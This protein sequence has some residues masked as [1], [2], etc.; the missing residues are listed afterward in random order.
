M[1][2]VKSHMCNPEL[3]SHHRR[4]IIL[5]YTV[6]LLLLQLLQ[7]THTKQ[8]YMYLSLLH[9][10]VMPSQLKHPRPHYPYNTMFNHQKFVWISPP[11]SCITDPLQLL[12]LTVHTFCSTNIGNLY[13]TC[14]SF[15]VL[16]WTAYF[17]L[18]RSKNFLS[19]FFSNIYNIGLLYTKQFC[20]KCN[21]FYHSFPSQQVSAS[22]GHH[23]T[24][25][26]CQN[27]SSV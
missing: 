16:P 4:C 25:Q 8:S 13:K 9:P 26:L 5:L 19:S 24:S 17:I 11:L 12:T 10:S 15:H 20:Q 21:Y 22:Y 14:S 2:W 18:L 7:S 6:S 27:C 3:Y 23:Q 1:I